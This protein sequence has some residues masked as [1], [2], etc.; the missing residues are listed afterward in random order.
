M[1]MLVSLSVMSVRTLRA[2]LLAM[3][4]VSNT[5][6]TYPIRRIHI[7]YSAACPLRECLSDSTCHLPWVVDE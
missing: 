1:S 6:T 2:V 7:R 3:I 5:I 4:K